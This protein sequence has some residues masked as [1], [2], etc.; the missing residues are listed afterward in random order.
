MK[1]LLIMVAG[2]VWAATAQAASFDCAKAGT[3]VE[4]LICADAELSKLDEE[5]NAAYKVALQKYGQAKT[6]RGE[7]SQWIKDRDSCERKNC[8]KALYQARLQELSIEP[9]LFDAMPPKILVDTSDKP[10]FDNETDKLKFMRYIANQHTFESPQNPANSAFCQQFFEDFSK[11]VHVVAV[12]PD[13]R[14]SDVNDPHLEKWHQCENKEI[15]PDGFDYLQLLGGPPYRYYQI[16]IDGNPGNGKEDV[17][18]TDY[19]KAP[20]G[21]TVGQNSYYWIDLEK[22]EFMGGGDITSLT[23][24]HPI[25]PNVYHLNSI[26]KYKDRYLAVDLSPLGLPDYSLHANTIGA[27]LDQQ[28]CFWPPKGK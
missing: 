4:K 6:T 7:Q 2:L 26:V 13:V 8:L 11:G 12:E 15:A 22:C 25:P 10:V 17:I 5:L 9:A 28:I 23:P 19:K 27:K 14:A 24:L 1:R 16:D 18:Y 20:S 3:K 21:G